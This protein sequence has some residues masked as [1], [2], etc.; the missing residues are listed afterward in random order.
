MVFSKKK[1][2]LVFLLIFSI[3]TLSQT[4]FSKDIF[5]DGFESGNLT[6]WIL[7]NA[8]DASN[9]TISLED[10]YIGIYHIEARP[11]ENTEPASIIKKAISTFDYNNIS[12][13][14]HR[15]LINL[16]SNDE[17]KSYW[18]DGLSWIV[19]EQT[20]SNQEDDTNYLLKSFNLNNNATNNTN[21]QIKFEC[22]A[23]SNNEYCR[24][25]NVNL[26]G[27]LITTTSTT[28]SSS[29]TTSTST[30]SSST[31]QSTT[32][33]TTSTTLPI[34]TTT[35]QETT[36]TS[37]TTSTTIDNILNI[38]LISPL[39]NSTFT[40]SNDVT[41]Q[42]DITSINNISNCSLM[43]NNTLDQTN[44]NIST[45]Q[46][47]AFTKTLLNSDYLWFVTCT[48]YNSYTKDSSI[49]ALI[50]NYIPPNN[51]T[52]N[53]GGGGGGGGNRPTNPP[54]PAE[55]NIR[56]ITPVLNPSPIP[57]LKKQEQIPEEPKK[58]EQIKKSS[59]FD[60]LKSFISLTSK[61]ISEKSNSISSTNLIP[62]VILCLLVLFGSFI[63]KKKE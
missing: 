32:T 11:K 38:E 59:I 5:F 15:R 47:Q 7:T 45:N 30:S 55:N 44:L 56:E 8:E 19:L 20:G 34:T 21:F 14:Y 48:D 62:L 41:F 36:T 23:N 31:T 37:S 13:N 17:F 12:I 27:T 52:P 54:T 24:I 1:R 9:W 26:S 29:S 2:L 51:P 53:T 43:I 57:E 28:S 50:V 25:D 33:S 16:D 58:I 49:F 35:T 6:G 42:Y 18:Y 60:K 40:I 22:T 10:P 4:I 61:A 39:D 3:I 46:I 63:K